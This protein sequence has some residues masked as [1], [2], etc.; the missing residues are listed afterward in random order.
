MASTVR[1]SPASSESLHLYLS[2]NTSPDLVDLGSPEDKEKEVA[3]KDGQGD[4]V[5]DMPTRFL[6][7]PTPSANVSLAPSS[8]KADPLAGTSRSGSVGPGE[9]ADAL[10]RLIIDET[11]EAAEIEIDIKEDVVSYI[12]KSFFE[13]IRSAVPLPGNYNPEF[14]TGMIPIIFK[15][16]QQNASLSRLGLAGIPGVP[17]EVKQ[18]SFCQEVNTDE[19]PLVQNELFPVKS[20]QTPPRIDDSP[21]FVEV[22]NDV[23]S[24]GS[25]QAD[26][27]WGDIK[28]SAGDEAYDEVGS[29]AQY[30]EDVE[31]A[32]A[33]SKEIAKMV[34]KEGQEK[35]KVMRKAMKDKKRELKINELPSWRERKKL[36]MAKV[37]KPSPKKVKEMGKGLE[38]AVQEKM[39][40]QLSEMPTV[41]MEEAKFVADTVSRGRTP[42]EKSL[43]QKAL[44]VNC[45]V[46]L[47]R[48]RYLDYFSSLGYKSYS[49]ID[50]SSRMENP[51]K[52]LTF[53]WSIVLL[54]SDI[55]SPHIA[56]VI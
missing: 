45:Y 8:P 2:P 48:Y 5:K 33:A 39:K 25:A 28:A 38:K 7:S 15:K 9:A 31:T 3:A 49:A 26:Q 13:L 4:R 10:G 42:L 18:E 14:A 6:F 27:T 11:P 23:N 12:D 44:T 35:A 30:L 36:A 37:K 24:A 19:I 41:V 34:K 20:K 47:T 22:T 29:V 1:L 53:P 21:R 52:K 46:D 50:F 54:H 55:D 16:G 43:I 32:T 40:L 56:W 17:E 51:L